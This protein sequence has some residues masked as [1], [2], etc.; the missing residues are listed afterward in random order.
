MSLAANWLTESEAVNAGTLNG[1]VLVNPAFSS[2]PG[3]ICTTNYGDVDSPVQQ[4]H[5]RGCS[6]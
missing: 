2:M 1:E 4:C 5:L 6:R 3:E